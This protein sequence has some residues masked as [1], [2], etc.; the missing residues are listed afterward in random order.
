M[1]GSK[2]PWSIAPDEESQPGDDG[3]ESFES[4]SREE[5][6]ATRRAGVWL[7]SEANRVASSMVGMLGMFG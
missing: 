3:R 1:P 6:L 2:R 7:T 4:R 5:G